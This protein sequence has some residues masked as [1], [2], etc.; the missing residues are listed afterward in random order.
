MIQCLNVLSTLPSRARLPARAFRLP[1]IQLD[2][3]DLLEVAP[4]HV[5]H[6]GEVCAGLNQRVQVEPLRI[7]RDHALLYQVGHF[8]LR[9]AFELPNG[10]LDR[11]RSV[12]IPMKERAIAKAFSNGGHSVVLFPTK[13]E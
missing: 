4:L 12:L 6:V 1:V 8:R 11:R 2:G 5:K 10:V 3:I 7:L 13:G 9:R